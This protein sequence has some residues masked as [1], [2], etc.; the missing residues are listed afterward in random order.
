MYYLLSCPREYCAICLIIEQ[1]IFLYLFKYSLFNMI[2]VLYV[3]L[4]CF[5][6][7]MFILK[8][9][10]ANITSQKDQY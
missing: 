10:N 2:F 1:Y 6:R 7:N 4:H 8:F 5:T 9:V 3:V